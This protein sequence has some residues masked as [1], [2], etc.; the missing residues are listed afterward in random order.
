MLYRSIYWFNFRVIWD[1]IIILLLYE[2]STSKLA[3]GF[4]LLFE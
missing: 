1:F 4:S 3:D 2:F